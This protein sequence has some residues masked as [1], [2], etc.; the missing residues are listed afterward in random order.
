MRSLLQ[1]APP[2]VPPPGPPA[3]ASACLHAQGTSQ[4]NVAA[5][6]EC[7][8]GSPS[9]VQASLG[10]PS[11]PER[12]RPGTASC[13]TSGWSAKRQSGRSRW[14]RPPAAQRQQQQQG[15]QPPLP[16]RQGLYQALQSGQQQGGQTAGGGPRGR[17]SCGTQHMGMRA[18]LQQSDGQALTR[19]ADPCRSRRRRC[20]PSPV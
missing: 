15:E 7:T 6:L 16:P 8:V 19:W 11:P 4:V 13:L 10:P 14:P 2:R 12:L 5:G 20:Q 1:A 17:G 9:C 3:A 18:H